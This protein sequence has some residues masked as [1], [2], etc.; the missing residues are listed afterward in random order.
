MNNKKLGAGLLY[1]YRVGL[2]NVGE[3]VF[4]GKSG[5][6]ETAALLKED[7]GINF[8]GYVE[9][10]DIYTGNCDVIVCDGF[11]GNV[12]L[13][14]S[15]GLARMISGMI[16]NAFRRDALS[17]ACGAFAS[18]VL[19]RLRRDMDSRRY[20]GACLLGMKNL[21]VKSHGNAD[22]TAFYSALN[23][24]MRAARQ[25]LSGAVAAAPQIAAA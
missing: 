13:K 20:N 18:P 1:Q 14:T 23:Y 6:K 2:L 9:G 19:A 3:E 17:A 5:L 15:E 22:D 16:K 7:S 4:K 25:D 10:F 11:T 12:A 24:A 21:V 8:T